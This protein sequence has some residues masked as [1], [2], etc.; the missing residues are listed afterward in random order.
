MFPHLVFA[1]SDSNDPVFDIYLR[2]TLAGY[3]SLH[4]HYL[5]ANGLLCAG[6]AATTVPAAA[7]VTL[8]YCV[9]KKVGSFISMVTVAPAAGGYHVT[10]YQPKS[11]EVEQLHVDKQLLLDVGITETEFKTV[12]AAIVQRLALVGHDLMLLPLHHTVTI[13]LLSDRAGILKMLSVVLACFV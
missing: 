13:S 12:A 11:R 9:S 6:A 8:K 3:Q 2:A 1:L 4:V 5:R 7:P 10:V